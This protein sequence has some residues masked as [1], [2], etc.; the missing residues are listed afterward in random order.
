MISQLGFSKHRIF[1]SAGPVIRFL[2]VIGAERRMPCSLFL[3]CIIQGS[4]GPLRIPGSNWP[5]AASIFR[6]CSAPFRKFHLVVKCLLFSDFVSL[7]RCFAMCFRW[8]FHADLAAA[9][10]KSSH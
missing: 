5:Q 1:F 8:I 2:L 10:L 7:R 9:N 6:A 4:D 3:T